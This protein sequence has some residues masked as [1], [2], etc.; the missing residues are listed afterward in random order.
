MQGTTPIL[1]V[2]GVTKSFGRLMAL[3]DVSFDAYPGEILS[4]IGPN[5]AGKTTLFNV[6]SGI[7]APDSGEIWFDGQNTTKLRTFEISRLGIA[8]TFQFFRLFNNMPGFASALLGTWK[9][10][11]VGWFECML[12]LPRAK[13]EDNKLL[14][15]IM[16]ELA[17]LG[18]LDKRIVPPP[19]TMTMR[20][21]RALTIGRAMASK[22]KLLLLDEPAAGLN[23]EEIG[24][25]CQHFLRY[26]KQGITMLLIDHRMEIVMDIS[27]RIV[28]LNF[29]RKIAEGTPAD[30][31]NN[32][33]VLAVYLGERT[34]SQGER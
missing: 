10:S 33:E 22:P 12:N 6:I 24:D 5:G 30:I 13:D 3:E 8:S 32:H 21:Q 18:I 27:D 31:Q 15:G 34:A 17:K 25:L 16:V 4:I 11:K 26:K 9:F 28:V 2:R 7:L 23:S 19:A 29:G 14:H 20:D 1:Q